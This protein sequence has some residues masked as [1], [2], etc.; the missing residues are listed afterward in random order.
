MTQNKR[1]IL[2]VPYFLATDAAKL[3]IK[4]MFCAC[5]LLL[6]IGY[7]LPLVGTWIASVLSLVFWQFFNI[8]I[9]KSG[10]YKIYC[11]FLLQRLVLS[12]VVAMALF[13]YMVSKNEF[14]PSYWSYYVSIFA[15]ISALDIYLTLKG[16]TGIGYIKWQ[17]K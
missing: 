16:L 4:L 17:K 11:S 7:F 8:K 3:P 15:L 2:N 1:F 13:M 10:K 5:H 9:G 12:N 6:L 14:N